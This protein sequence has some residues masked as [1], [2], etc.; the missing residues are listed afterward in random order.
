MMFRLTLV[1][2]SLWNRRL[3]TSLTLISL[4]VSVALLLAVERVRQG[5]RESFSGTISQTDLIVGARGGQLQLLLYS[6]FRIGN[7]TNNVSFDSFET[8]RNDSR[9]AW[10]IPYSLGDSHRGFRVVGTDENFY[11]H[12]RFRGGKSIELL[13]GR[14]ASDVFD[15]TIG[16][17]VAEKL[18]YQEGEKIVLTHGAV[19][20]PS[21]FQHTDT[22]FTVVGILKKTNT[23][24]DKSL[25]ITLQGMEAMHM[26]WQEGAPSLEENL[27]V[28]GLRKEDIR[29]G[30]VTA[31]LVR[32][33]S[34]I[35]V[36][37]LQR[38]IN[39]FESEPL[40]AIIP[41]VAL[42]ELWST[43][44]YA[45]SG[46]RVVTFFVI[47]VGLVG[48]L[49]SLYTA[50]E[51][52]RREMAIL[53]AVGAGTGT[54]AV[55]MLSEALVLCVL[56]ACLGLGLAYGT[57]FAIR[58]FVDAELGIL[59]P[60]TFLSGEEWAYLAAFVVLGALL[61]LVPAWRAIRNS[62]ADGLTVRL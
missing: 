24:I 40:M 42:S 62:L 38:S 58:P 48:M 33:K 20:S 6:I 44:S 29:I 21:A 61:G 51:S 8:I 25:Y 45:E 34:R 11:A 37:Q 26:G 59:L 1:L 5:A 14:A 30:Q 19:E 27:R 16:S 2:K 54:L 18:G 36:L 56:G 4:A 31:F 15:V 17:D 7:A 50:L 55:L 46:L 49:I 22:P 12:Y 35:Q 23:P 53:R 10:T 57:L 60:V 47:A 13:A 52:R 9:V 32:A 41:G 28:S 39:N 3:V 43:V